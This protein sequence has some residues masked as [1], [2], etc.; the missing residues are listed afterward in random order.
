MEA[1]GPGC[2]ILVHFQINIVCVCV[3]VCVHV[4]VSECGLHVCVYVFGCSSAC[5]CQWRPEVDTGHLPV[6]LIF[7]DRVSH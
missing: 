1:C 6:H 4:C 2:V 5:I 7:W 3:C